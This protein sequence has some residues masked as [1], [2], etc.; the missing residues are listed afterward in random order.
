MA[1]FTSA[2][3][4]ANVPVIVHIGTNILAKKGVHVKRQIPFQPLKKG[5]SGL[6]TARF[7]LNLPICV[8]LN[9][10]FPINLANHLTNPSGFVTMLS[11]SGTITMNENFRLKGSRYEHI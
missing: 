11:L 4:P 7:W 10:K 9:L 8:R 1:V 5:E 3:V 6:K 2:N